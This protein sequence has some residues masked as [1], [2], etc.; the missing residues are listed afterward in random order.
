MNKKEAKNKIKKLRNIINKHNELYFQ[1]EDPDISDEEYD[2]LM[3]QLRRLEN[4]YPEF[5]TKDSPSNT[6]GGYAENTFNDVKHNP[7]MLSLGKAMTFEEFKKWI[8][9]ICSKGV[10]DFCFE[11]KLDGLAVSLI[12]KDGKL[13][14][15]ATRG[16]GVTGEDITE[17]VKMIPNIPN[18]LNIKDSF[19][20]RGEVVL[21]KKSLKEINNKFNKDYKNPRNTASGFLRTK[22]P[23]YKLIRYLEF[24]AY[25]LLPDKQ[26]KVYGKQHDQD[27]S[28]L[29]TLGFNL[30]SDYTSSL[31]KYFRDEDFN[32]QLKNVKG[33]FNQIENNRDKYK[34][35]ID[36]IV[37][38]ATHYSDQNK[39]GEKTDVPEWAIS[40]KFASE[41]KITIL[42][43]VEWLLG[44][45]GNITPRAQIE[46]VKIAGSTIVK[47]TLHNVDEIKRLGVKIGDSVKVER[48]GDVI[49]KI[50]EVVE[51]LRTGDE[52]EI[53]I[54]TVCPE[55]GEGL[56]K[57]GT[58]IRC[59]NPICEGRI[60]YLIQNWVDAVEID[61][62]SIKTLE[63]LYNNNKIKTL[64]DLYDLNIS[65]IANLEGLGE[66]MGKKLINNIKK[67]QKAPLPKVILGLSIK[68]IGKRMGRDLA[69]KYKKLENFKNVKYDELIK[70]N[71]VGPKIANNIINWVS[72]DKHQDLLKQL[73]KLNIGQ[74]KYEENNEGILK[75]KTFAFSGKLSQSRSKFKEIIKKHGGKP[76]SNKKGL[77]YFL[78]GKGAKD[79]K[80]EKARNNG[81]K[82]LSEDEFWELLK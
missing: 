14:Q 82:V 58:Y 69:L 23:D 51:D 6:I 72:K 49:P 41:Q 71:G 66:K 13:I 8:K 77:D 29:C 47:P 62:L 39:L 74:N 33:F 54:P 65:D 45:K 43:D 67:S 64:V 22:E 28:Y 24:G 7:K 78:A 18:K 32:K 2:Q 4:K 30:A 12:Y 31:R 75:G 60:I 80:K 35:D 56:T 20:I 34:V 10:K 1:Q 42:L 53:E 9:D 38:K 61:E 27:M 68:G 21:P 25:M 5:I 15:G 70:M 40:Y 57:D 52:K 73:I 76:S 36:G 19:E 11:A 79:H 63:K 3:V 44:A 81:A 26:T 50:V 37:I 46:P 16:D 55:C 17:T 59:D 48:R